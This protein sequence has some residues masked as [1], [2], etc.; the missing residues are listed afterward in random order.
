MK[1][2]VDKPLCTGCQHCKDVCPVA[3]FEMKKRSAPEE[4]NT[5]TAPESAQWKGQSD[6][7][8][9]EKWSKVEDGHKHF[10]D[11]N[12]GTSG[13]I[14]VGVNGEA[15]ILCQACLIQCEGE[16]IH[17]IDDTNTEYKS[18]YA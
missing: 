17:I 10:A 9:V 13:G 12:D 7:A 11:E 15:C 6:P 4:V 14:S 1:V 8:I 18:I 2:Y 16:C 3:V 5:D